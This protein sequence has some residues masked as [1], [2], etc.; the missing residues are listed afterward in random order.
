MTSVLCHSVI[1]CPEL[2][3]PLNGKVEILDRTVG[4]QALYTCKSEQFCVDGLIVRSCGGDGNWEGSAPTCINVT[5]VSC[6]PLQDPINGRLLA[7]TTVSNRGTAFYACNDGFVVAD[8]SLLRSCQ[9]GNPGVW[10]DRPPV[11]ERK[12]SSSH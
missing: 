6:P 1:L 3:D 9:C 5:T 11:C 12:I 4:S 8:G 7:V 10:S 2:T